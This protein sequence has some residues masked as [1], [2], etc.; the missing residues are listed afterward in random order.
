M[1]VE[2]NVATH[3][4]KRAVSEIGG[5]LFEGLENRTLLSASQL[6]ADPSIAAIPDASGSSIAGYTPAQIR[7]A[8]G[9]SSVTL[10]NGVAGTGAGQTIA[11]VDAYNDPNIS[12][13]LNAFDSEYGLSAA[14]LK[15][16]SQT[17][18][19]TSLPTTNAGWDLE[20]SLDVEWAHAIAP[21]ANILLVEASSSSLGNLLTAVNYARNAAGVSVVS[22][23]WGSS[24][25]SSET[26]YDSY[27][28]T[29]SGHQGVTFVAASG[30]EGSWYGP[31]WPASSPNVLSVGGTTLN[32]ANSSGTYGSETA[33]SDSTGGIS[34]YEREPS[35]QTIAQLTGARTTPDV[36]YDA[37]PNTGFAVYDSVTY[38][39]DKGWWEVGGTSA[40]SPQ[41]AAL[42]AIAD[43]GRAVQG[44]GT[45]NG[46]SQ[47]LPLL[48]SLYNSTQ[49]SQAYHDETVGASSWFF[50]A[51]PGYDAVT[52]LGSPKAA[53]VIQELIGAG[54]TVTVSAATISTM[55]AVRTS[56]P[57]PGIHPRFTIDPSAGGPQAAAVAVMSSAES[58]A[59]RA[60]SPRQAA[61]FETASG[62]AGSGSAA[63]QSIKTNR[64]H[65]VAGSFL[66][67]RWRGAFADFSPTLA[68]ANVDAQIAAATG[69]FRG[70]NAV[71][72]IGA[73]A[74]FV[75]KLV[76]SEATALAQVANTL[77]V[78]LYDQ[79]AMIWKESA[80]L[81]GAAIIVGMHAAR[82]RPASQ[83]PVRRRKNQKFLCVGEH[84]LG[85]IEPGI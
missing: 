40:G 62:Q 39:G 71:S 83:V 6:L 85:A 56:G 43:Q 31:E 53:Y 59:N 61:E 14:S 73:S 29:P 7:T 38:E 10:S 30:D 26:Q 78:R 22:M 82:G 66:S 55:V 3:G 18:S 37:N 24:E 81:L 84:G 2:N 32:L 16:V 35:Y 21:G 80:G 68:V 76:I 54:S 50:S 44:L 8:Y 67:G 42:V 25:F 19:T 57:G 64:E 46:T 79:D 27:F 5:P 15:V 51:G 11:I 33:W 49:Y 48:Y 60:S 58:S 20:I 70:F 34:R 47:T 1:S 12:S 23:S 17:G 72:A 52:G 9:F 75:D 74:R 13:D 45:L 36:A 41:W 69:F 28:T 77:A 63:F 4:K 65:D